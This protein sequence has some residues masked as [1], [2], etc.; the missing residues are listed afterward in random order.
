MHNLGILDIAAMVAVVLAV[1]LLG[2]RLSGSIQTRNSFF[3]AD[4]TMPWWAVSASIIATLVSSVTFVSVP[5]AVFRDGGDLTYLQVI[6][7]LAIGKFFI[8]GILVRSFYESRDI[9]TTYEYIGARMDTATG[10]ASLWIGLLLN[11]INSAIKL[12]AAA[13]VLDVAT[14]WGVTGCA[15]AVVAFS[16]LWSALAGIKTVIWTDFLLFVLFAAGALLSLVLL[17][18]R[19]EAPLSDA[20]LWLDQQAKLT[21]FDFSTDLERRYTLWAA[22]LGS[23]GLSLALGSTQGTWQRVHACRS[24]GDAQKAYNYSALFYLMHLLILAI[25]LGL[26]LFYREQP[27]DPLVA[28][29]V[30]AQPDRIFPYFILTEIPTGLSGLFIAAIFA[31]AI[32]TLDSAMTEASELTVRHLYEPL[33]ARL[34]RV[35][36]ETEY[37]RV[38]RLSLLLWGLAFVGGAVFINRFSGEGLLDLTFKLPNYLYGVTFATILL[39]R[40]RIGTFPSFCVGVAVACAAVAWMATSDIAFFWWCPTAGAAMIAV[41]VLLERVKMR[42]N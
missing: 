28:S 13:I 20:M 17:T 36:T 14:N 38:S 18:L 19:I 4:G 2:H 5:A 8:A 21:L 37:L 3:A 34:K 41:V 24:V 33:I 23:I 35:A 7:G 25:G 6:I 12:L 39:A 10:T 11:L 27:L 42:S 9:H 16:I 1:T 32:S 26:A 30:S 40:F 29:A 22:I 15:L 31:A